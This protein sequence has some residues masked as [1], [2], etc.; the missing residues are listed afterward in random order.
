M[1][2]MS[3]SAIF[4]LVLAAFGHSLWNLLTKRSYDKHVFV[5]LAVVV[6]VVL[7]APFAWLRAHP[8]DAVGWGIVFASGM[9]QL[10]YYLLLGGAYARGDMSLVYPLS[11][12]SSPLFVVLIAAIWQGERPSLL[13][14]FG[15][16]LIVGGVYLVPLA[17][18][19]RRDL[20]APLASLRSRASQ[21]A[22]LTGVVI[23]TYSAIDKIGVQHVDPVYYYFLV[24]VVSIVGL[25]PYLWLR[26]RAETKI[27]LRAHW[28]SILVVGATIVAG[29]LVILFVLQTSPVA[30]ATSIRGISV[31]F[32]SLMGILVL[33]EKFTVPKLV[34]AVLMFCGVVCIG[35][36]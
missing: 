21:L 1:L 9:A 5:V 31:V 4:A 19:A 14:A 18:L 6:G 2:L 26:R 24:L 34:G 10:V 12:G 36:A 15:I 3:A 33:K 23:A 11:R 29:Y 25:L 30:Y 13:G 27:E 35:L 8:I 20:F 7:L 22:L 28:R 16:A 17:S 32:G